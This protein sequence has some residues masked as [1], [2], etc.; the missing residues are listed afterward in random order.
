MFTLSIRTANAA[1]EGD[2]LPEVARLLALASA[3]VEGGATA[4]SLLDFNGNVAGAFSFA[5]DES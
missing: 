1:F 2:P 3:K 5:E 4:G